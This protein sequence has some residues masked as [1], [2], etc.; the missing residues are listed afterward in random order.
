MLQEHDLVSRARDAA[1]QLRYMLP[2]FEDR[3]FEKRGG[4]LLYAVDADVF[5]VYGAPHQR[6]F[7]RVFFDDNA[8]LSAALAQRLTDHIFFRVAPHKPML[9]VPPIEQDIGSIMDALVLKFGSEPPS[10]NVD[11][12]ELEKNIE[13]LRTSGIAASDRNTIYNLILKLVYLRTGAPATYRALA[14]LIALDR[15]AGPEAM[16]KAHAEVVA[17]QKVFRPFREIQDIYE[18]IKLRDTWSK[19]LA[20]H[21]QPS[22]RKRENLER[23]AD[24]IARIDIWNRQLN[25]SNIRILYITATPL[26]HEA[27]LRSERGGSFIRHP[28][29]FLAS[30]SVFGDLY[31]TDLP[32]DASAFFGW[33]QTFVGSI[34]KAERFESDRPFDLSASFE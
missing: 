9:V 26:I 13:Q 8:D 6:A 2:W 17:L 1:V 23:D 15:I 33:L 22:G 19:R 32:N 27:V 5:H 12:G 21:R 16:A 24:C 3:S 4:R 14:R 18:H 34:S 30:E 29:Y 10:L 31:R 25:K 11:F 7:G 28:R 20:K